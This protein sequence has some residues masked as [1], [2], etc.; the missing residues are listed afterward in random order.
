VTLDCIQFPL[1]N[2]RREWCDISG[3]DLLTVIF[4]D[5]RVALMLDAEQ[6][7]SLDLQRCEGFF[8][9]FSA[10]PSMCLLPWQGEKV[11]D[12]PDEGFFAVSVV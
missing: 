5:E 4:W 9:A 1:R 3:I 8:I 7:A 6:D 10:A 12:R 11:A 2:E